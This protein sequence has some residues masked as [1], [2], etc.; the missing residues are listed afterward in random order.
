MPPGTRN[1]EPCL[2]ECF[3][4]YARNSEPR[5]FPLHLTAASCISR[6]RTPP[7]AQNSHVILQLTGAY[8]VSTAASYFDLS[9][10]F[11]GMS[12][13]GQGILIPY[14]P[15]FFHINLHTSPHLFVRTTCFS[16]LHH[17]F[18]HSYPHF[19]QQYPHLPHQNPQLSTHFST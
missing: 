10:G 13:V 9:A 6:T 1:A 16:T 2:S 17:T 7:P 5:P 4:T 3:P 12:Q 14:P 11:G 19:P 18:P 8:D 15:I